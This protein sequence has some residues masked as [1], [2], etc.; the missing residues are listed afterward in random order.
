ML[1]PVIEFDGIDIDQVPLT[2][3]LRVIEDGLDRAQVSDGVPIAPVDAI[4][5]MK[6]LAGRIQD[7]ADVEAMVESGADRVF[8]RAAVQKA[9]P[10]PVAHPRAA[11]GERRSPALR[12]RVEPRRSIAPALL[13]RQHYDLDQRL[14][15]HELGAHRGP[16]GEGR[17]HHLAVDLVHA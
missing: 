12:A 17:A 15:S 11:V 10:G 4:V 16:R 14:R 3:T 1:V 9:A 8:L 7:L 6:L 13:H 5:I 2:D